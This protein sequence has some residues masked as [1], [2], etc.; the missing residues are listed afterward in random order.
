LLQSESGC[1]D[2]AA[3]PFL[4]L[5]IFLLLRGDD[6]VGKTVGKWVYLVILYQIILGTAIGAVIG[7]LARKGMKFAKR[8]QII[9]R[10]SMVAM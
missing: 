2:G 10:E 4:Y 6:S 3:F 7:V 1:N 8:R 5:S 9:D